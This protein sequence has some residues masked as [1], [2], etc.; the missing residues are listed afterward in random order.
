ME[1]NESSAK[2]KVHSTKCIHKETKMF[3]YQQFKSTLESSREK[4]A[5][6]LTWS[7]RQKISKIRAEVNQLETKKTIQRIHKMKSYF[8]EKINKIDRQDSQTN[9]TPDSIQINNI[10]NEK[11]DITTDTEE[12]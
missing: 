10:I 3:L 11:G 1:H 9:Q 12:I 6:T 2:S 7:R 5:N 8:F 4:E